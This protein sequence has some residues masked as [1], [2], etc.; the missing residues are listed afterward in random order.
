VP[1]WK[2][3]LRATVRERA[4]R[5]KDW[6]RRAS[7]APKTFA[8]GRSHALASN[9]LDR[10]EIDDLDTPREQMIAPAASILR[11]VFR[12]RRAAN[13]EHLSEKFVREHDRVALGSVTGF[14]PPPA[15]RRLDPMQRITRRADPRLCE[16]LGSSSRVALIS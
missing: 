14:Q 5:T 3:G 13:A 12:D 11:D 6:F 16:Q 4:T 8:P 15:K 2:N 7:F 10:F 1:A 9:G